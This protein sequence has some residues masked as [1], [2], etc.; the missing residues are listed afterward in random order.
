[1]MRMMR[2]QT[3]WYRNGRIWR[4]REHWQSLIYRIF[5]NMRVDDR[6]TVRRPL[7]RRMPER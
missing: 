4:N 6:P 1:M 2:S 7:V 5:R 3:D